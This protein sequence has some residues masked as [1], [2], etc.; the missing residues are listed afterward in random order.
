MGEE[1]ADDVVVDGFHVLGGGFGHK[2]S[3]VQYVSN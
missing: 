3:H 1:A 2:G